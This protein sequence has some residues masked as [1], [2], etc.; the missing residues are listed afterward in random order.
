[1]QITEIRRLMSFGQRENM[2]M[3]ARLDEGEDPQEVLFD[4]ATARADKHGRSR[5]RKRPRACPDNRQEKLF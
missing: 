1:M 2:T 5:A 4:A 3:N